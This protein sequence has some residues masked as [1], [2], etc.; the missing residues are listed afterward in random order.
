VKKYEN[1]RAEARAAAAKVKALF[2]QPLE[3][4]EPDP[5]FMEGARAGHRVGQRGSTDYVALIPIEAFKGL[6]PS[7]G[8]ARFMALG[9]D[10][11][12][13]HTLPPAA[14]APGGLVRVPFRVH[15]EAAGGRLILVTGLQVRV[16][17]RE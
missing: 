16:G 3:W 2:E 13:I 7:G 12:E 10:P 11:N 5:D 14:P 1:A 6:F 8:E 17:P 15:P 4:Q 9:N